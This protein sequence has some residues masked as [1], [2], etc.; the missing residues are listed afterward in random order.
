MAYPTTWKPIP[1]MTPRSI[2][3]VKVTPRFCEPGPSSVMTA[4]KNM[5]IH[6]PLNDPASTALPQLMRPVIRST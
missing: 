4:A 6:S 3:P 1:Q 2:A 5:P